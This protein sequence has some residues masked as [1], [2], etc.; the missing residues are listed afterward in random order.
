MALP[1]YV[2]GV[3]MH[4]GSH[5]VAAKLAGAEILEVSLLPSVRDGHF[6][7]GYTRWRGQLSVPAKAW[8]LIAPK[9]TNATIMTGYAFLVG[10]DALPGNDYGSL[11]L[12]VFATAAWVD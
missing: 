10:F 8:T 11:A 1:A 2:I 9:I 3:A 5:A 7:F 4:E 12:T 6:Y